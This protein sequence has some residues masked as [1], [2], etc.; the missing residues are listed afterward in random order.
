MS[1]KIGGFAAFMIV[2]AVAAAAERIAH[3]VV[4]RPQPKRKSAAQ[5]A[6]WQ[7]LTAAVNEVRE[8]PDYPDVKQFMDAVNTK[9]AAA[10]NAATLDAR[11]RG[12]LDEF[13][14]LLEAKWVAINAG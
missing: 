9:T 13:L 4:N 14:S 3:T 12:E 10:F 5:E 2:V 6:Y 11:T 7:A 1:V 8:G